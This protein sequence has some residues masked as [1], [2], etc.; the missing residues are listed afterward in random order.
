M[1]NLLVYQ[2]YH[3]QM[4]QSIPV[5]AVENTARSGLGPEDIISQVWEETEVSV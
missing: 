3:R 1:L 4:D 5:G 2:T